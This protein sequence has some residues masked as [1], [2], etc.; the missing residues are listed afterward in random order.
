MQMG[1][2]GDLTQAS[3]FGADGGGGAAKASASGVDG[4]R[5]SAK[6]LAFILVQMG[7]GEG[8]QLRHQLLM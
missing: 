1:K 7:R 5:G 6:A 8:I 2:G 4:E 3:A